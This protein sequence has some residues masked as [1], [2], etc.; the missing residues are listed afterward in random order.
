M[1]VLIIGLLVAG[2]GVGCADDAPADDADSTGVAT[3]SQ[4]TGLD[5]TTTP[6]S[7][8]AVATTTSGEATTSSADDSAS[9]GTGV[10]TASSD[11]SSGVVDDGTTA[12]TNVL[13]TAVAIPGGLD[14]LQIRKADMD[15]NR[16]LWVT[17]VWP[18][19]GGGGA[20]PGVTTPAEWGVDNIGGNDDAAAC[21]ADV[22]SMFGGEAADD[23]SGTVT[24]GRLGGAGH[25]PCTVDIDVDLQFPGLLVGTEETMFATGL[26]VEGA[27]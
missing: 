6:A 1:R 18:G 10:V 8:G 2:L 3:T 20:F 17:L 27:C 16:C 5:N 7:T 21:A 24:F 23:A 26:V 25:Y 15:Q 22:P 19:E 11:G 13:Y 4:T 14:R 12:A 9:T